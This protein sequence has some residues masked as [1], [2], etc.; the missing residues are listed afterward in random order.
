MTKTIFTLFC[1]SVFSLTAFA[2]ELP[3]KRISGV[4]NYQGV[5][6]VQIR[7]VEVIPYANQE[8][9]RE[10]RQLNFT[11]EVISNFYKCTKFIKEMDL[12]THIADEINNRWMGRAFE[13]TVSSSAPLL[14]NEA[15][16]LLEWDVYDSVSSDADIAPQYR[17]Y[18]LNS[19]LHKIRVNFSAKDQWFVVHHHGHLSSLISKRVNIS[20]TKTREYLLRLNFFKS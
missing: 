20:K 18:L 5:E 15:P 1:A 17:Y 16:A 6:V 12:P 13:F 8:R 19:S 14:I 7:E 4:F 3:L 10:L 2:N 9:Y 11:C